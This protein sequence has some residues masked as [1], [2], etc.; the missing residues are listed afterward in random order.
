MGGIEKSGSVVPLPR[1]VTAA[2]SGLID[3]S[4]ISATPEDATTSIPTHRPAVLCIN[5][6]NGQKLLRAGLN[7]S[8]QRPT[9]AAIRG[10]G[11]VTAKT[12]IPPHGPTGVGVDKGNRTQNKSAT[13]IILL[14][15]VCAAVGGFRDLSQIA[16]RN[17]GV[18]V[19]NMNIV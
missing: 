5:E 17:G 14:A 12:L 1:S 3:D 11:D 15:P 7:G 2:V 10:F 4:K 19:K 13:G 8:L 9:G 6:M 18:L 16:D